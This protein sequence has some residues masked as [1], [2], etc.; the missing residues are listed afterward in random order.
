MKP[1]IKKIEFSKAEQ[2][3]I[4]LIN[5]GQIVPTVRTVI[6]KKTG[7]KQDIVYHKRFTFD[8]ARKRLLQ[9]HG[10]LCRCGA[11]PNYKVM[12]DVGDKNQGA[13][14]V[15][16]FCQSCYDKQYGENNKK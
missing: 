12:V 5:K 3:E 1:V 8:T 2:E 14:L 4:D 10:G 15:S 9:L 7:V 6:D 16:R 11:W 13:W